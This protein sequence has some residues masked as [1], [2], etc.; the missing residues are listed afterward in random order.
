MVKKCEKC[1][2]YHPEKECP[3]EDTTT[4]LDRPCPSQAG[5]FT[6]YE[7]QIKCDGRDWRP[8]PTEKVRDGQG[9]PSPRANRGIL[10]TLG[11]L[12]Y[13]QAQSLAWLI[14][15]VADAELKEVEVR[16]MPFDVQYDAK[17]YRREVDIVA[18]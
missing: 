13:K 14:L 5:S 15:A 7:V 8:A 10:D 18:F 4:G 2:G 6:G 3:P 9:I 17:A 12:G 1:E 16:I 11:L